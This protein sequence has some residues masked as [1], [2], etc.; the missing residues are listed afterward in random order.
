MATPLQNLQSMAAGGGGLNPL[1]APTQTSQVQQLLTTK[2]TGRATGPT[3]APKATNIQEQIAL[4]QA[5]LQQQELQQ[6]GREAGSALGLQAAEA[7]QQY[8]QS[9]AELDEKQISSQEQY[10]RQ[11]EAVFRDLARGTRE[12]DFQRDSAKA[13][14]VGFQ[15]RLSNDRYVNNLKLEGM[16]SRLNSEIAFKEALTVSIFAEEEALYRSN[17]SFKSMIDANDRAF[18]ERLSEMDIELAIELASAE[19][20]G[21]AMSN[22]ISGFT[23]AFKGG[24]QAYSA[25]ESPTT[26]TIGGQTF[27]P[28][29]LTEEEV[30]QTRPWQQDA[31]ATQSTEPGNMSRRK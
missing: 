21:Q 14:Q 31:A 18:N 30:G 7:D 9:R 2:A 15:L 19:A 20:K 29:A 5:R 1:P 11:A 6:A 26:T 8:Q 27:N 3:A 25:Y 22:T 10:Q 13:E 16:R 24:V 4:N 23:Q 17:L 28:D 12:I